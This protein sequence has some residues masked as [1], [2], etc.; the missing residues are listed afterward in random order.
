MQSEAASFSEG[1]PWADEVKVLRTAADLS[2]RADVSFAGDAPKAAVSAVNSK[3]VVFRMFF[4]SSRTERQTVKQRSLN[5]QEP[6]AHH[7][8]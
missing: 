8:V 3:Q 2:S 4:D 6:P 1:M 5:S 7:F